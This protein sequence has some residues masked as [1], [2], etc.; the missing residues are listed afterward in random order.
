D[1]VRRGPERHGPQRH[2]PERSRREPP[3]PP[4]G[5]PDPQD[6][7]EPAGRSS[8]PPRDGD[9]RRRGDAPPGSGGRR[10]R[11]DD[12]EAPTDGPS[13]TARGG[14]PKPADRRSGA[15]KTGRPQP[16]AAGG[17]LQ[18]RRQLRQ[19]QRLRLLTLAFVTVVLLGALP[20]FFFIKHITRDPGFV[21][22]DE[23]E[24]PT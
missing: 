23:L 1:P 4:Q 8:R 7:G 3:R 14:K 5:R 21:A 19:V 6:R 2:G 11:G 12:A 15:P 10:R 18:A 16:A 9:R 20:G 24:L 17:R 13:R 22:M